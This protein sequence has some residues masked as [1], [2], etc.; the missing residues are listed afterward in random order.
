MVAVLFVFGL[1]RIRDCLVA[2]YLIGRAL[3]SWIL[4]KTDGGG[5]RFAIEASTKNCFDDSEP[6]PKLKLK[7]SAPEVKHTRQYENPKLNRFNEFRQKAFLSTR[8]EH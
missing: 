1:H 2:G 7:L 8:G 5:Y 6:K 4:S 3:W